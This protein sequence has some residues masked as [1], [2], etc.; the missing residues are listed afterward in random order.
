MVGTLGSA[1]TIATFSAK[2][3]LRAPRL[4]AAV[5]GPPLTSICER[6][7]LS[8]IVDSRAA[9]PPNRTTTGSTG[10]CALRLATTCNTCAQ[11]LPPPAA[12]GAAPP[13]LD[14]V[15]TP[16]AG[17]PPVVACAEQAPRRAA[18]TSRQAVHA[19]AAATRG[20]A[21]DSV[22]RWCVPIPKVPSRFKETIAPV[23]RRRDTATGA[24]VVL[25]DSTKPSAEEVSAREV[26]PHAHRGGVARTAGLRQ[27]PLQPHRELGARPLAGRP[28]HRGR[29]HA[30]LLRRPRRQRHVSR[31]DRRAKRRGGRRRGP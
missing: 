4:Y 25:P 24:D 28:R 26:P 14:P 3:R 11:S 15:A 9:E 6:Q 2:V 18:T 17:T 22:D 27:D 23:S 19:S 16:V 7:L 1:C 5:A 13:E 10:G 8:L 20:R 12:A 31:A 29:R 30:P 21:P